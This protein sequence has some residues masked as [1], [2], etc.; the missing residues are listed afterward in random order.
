MIL[1]IGFCVMEVFLSSCR[2][3]GGGQSIG[4]QS[5]VLHTI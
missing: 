3:E 2:W 5:V 1:A 4:V